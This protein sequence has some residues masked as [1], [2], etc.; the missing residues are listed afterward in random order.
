[1]EQRLL[2]KKDLLKYGGYLLD[3]ILLDGVSRNNSIYNTNIDNYYISKILVMN[4]VGLHIK[5]FYIDSYCMLKNIEEAGML[6][7]DNPELF[8]AAV[9][10]L[11]ELIKVDELSDYIEFDYEY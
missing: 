5:A 2:T 4:E 1:M 9:E 10:E 7:M 8:Y 6:I 11:K 3:R